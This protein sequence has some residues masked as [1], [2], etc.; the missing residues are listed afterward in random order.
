MTA[1]YGTG[2]KKDEVVNL[3]TLRS[4]ILVQ[5]AKLHHAMGKVQEVKMEKW[6]LD[7]MLKKTKEQIDAD[8]RD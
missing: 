7:E 1:E 3:D 6:T 4:L 8:H 5:R 2:E